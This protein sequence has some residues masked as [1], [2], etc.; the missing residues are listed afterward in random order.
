[1]K[2]K[3][4]TLFYFL[5]S[6]IISL[7]I[8]ALYT[9]TPVF[10]SIELASQDFRFSVFTQQHKQFNKNNI[11][12][13]GVDDKTI[14]KLTELNI[15]LL[16]ARDIYGYLLDKAM[17]NGAKVIAFDIM[18]Q[19]FDEK[20]VGDLYFLQSIQR[21]DNIVFSIYPSNDKDGTLVL[22]NEVFVNANKNVD[23]GFIKLSPD[24]NNTVRGIDLFNIHKE[25]EKTYIY[26]SFTAAIFKKLKGFKQTNDLDNYINSNFKLYNGKLL[27][28]FSGSAGSFE[29]IS[30]ADIIQE[31]T[32]KGDFD[33]SKF[34]DKIILVGATY[35]ASQDFYMSPYKNSANVKMT[36]SQ[37]R[38][39]GVEIHANALN[40]MINNNF[41][42]RFK[43]N[44]LLFIFISLILM[45]LLS[46]M[47]KRSFYST[48]SFL[49]LIITITALSLFLF[50]NNITLDVVPLYLNTFLIFAF[51]SVLK[52][53]VENLAKKRVERM[54]GK[55]VSPEVVK[56]LLNSNMNLSVGGTSQEVS[57]IFSDI[58]DF[59][60]ISE[61]IPA[62]KLV[63]LL[64]Q[65][66]NEMFLVIEKNNGMIDKYIGDAIMALYGAPIVNENHA[67]NSVSSAI[68]MTKAVQ[69]LKQDWKNACEIELQIRIGINSGNV[70]VGNIGS[71]KKLEYTAIGD[72]VNLASRLEGVNKYFGTSIIISEFTLA[73]LKD[74]TKYLYREIDLLK[75]KGKII[76]VKIYE[77]LDFYDNSSDNMRTT[78]SKFTTA[79]EL[80]RNMDF[81]TALDIFKSI[82]DDGP[83]AIYVERCTKF[84]ASPPPADWDRVFTLK[85]K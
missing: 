85:T 10:E 53:I 13:V 67:D 46:P 11:V 7:S 4:L 51:S 23:F 8:W 72:N 24:Q 64:N 44:F 19:S 28:N 79:L 84:I 47:L 40:T 60:T 5:V 63:H 37:L 55:Y 48:V 38:T 59:T 21:Y 39:P 70:V 36:S 1:M 58:A 41:I 42:L 17:S 73:L 20:N 9:F 2:N 43:P 25:Q 75:V 50:S 34:K 77:V 29:T 61:I 14:A 78:V 22:P 12:I 3:K 71:D 82:S 69:L 45:L 56:Q 32:G 31:A 66:F 16:A 30:L 35:G 49:M 80:Y 26:P 52:I 57:I 65:Y 68:A 54:F 74:K 18:F 15:T 33:Y 83:S 76:P 6:F 81:L 62:P 27:I